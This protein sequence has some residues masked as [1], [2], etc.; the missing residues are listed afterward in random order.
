MSWQG[1]S[2][3]IAF[4]YSSKSQLANGVR[5][6]ETADARIF[7]VWVRC[8][9]R[10]PL[11]SSRWR[12]APLCPPAR[13][14]ARTSRPSAARLRPSRMSA[15][16]PA[17]CSTRMPLERGCRTPPPTPP[18]AIATRTA[19]AANFRRK[20][21]IRS[22][23]RSSYSNCPTMSASP[24]ISITRRGLRPRS[25]PAA[26]WPTSPPSVRRPETWP[27]QGRPLRRLPPPPPATSIRST[28][29]APRASARPPCRSAMI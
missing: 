19:T 7:C 29:P 8:R 4:E 17:N 18:T 27:P 13:R 16:R 24:P 6:C 25:M 11:P 1:G 22:S 26:P 23:C 20:P 28:M 9:R 3:L 14:L 15:M 21:A 2:A 5:S 10:N 12:G